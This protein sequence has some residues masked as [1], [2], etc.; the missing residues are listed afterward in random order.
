MGDASGVKDGARGWS[1]E[2]GK[3]K[4]DNT[5]IEYNALSHDRQSGLRGRAQTTVFRVRIDQGPR[6]RFR[7]LPK[8]KAC[9][10]PLGNMI[11]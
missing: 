11:Q 6:H 5:H 7:H 9:V 8:L 4:H 2:T 3:G 10:C 1:R